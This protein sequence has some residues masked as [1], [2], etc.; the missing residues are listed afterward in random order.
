MTKPP[1]LARAELVLG[2]CREFSCLPSALAREDA[3]LLRLLAIEQMG[4]PPETDR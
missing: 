4:R 3:G 1:E 2:L